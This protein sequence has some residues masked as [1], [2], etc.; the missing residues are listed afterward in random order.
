M[1][2]N[3][4][5][6]LKQDLEAKRDLA[7]RCMTFVM[8]GRPELMKTSELLELFNYALKTATLEIHD[9]S[10]DSGGAE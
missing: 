6:R 8:M 10:L 7:V 2:R 9:L 4:R 1:D 5:E 3:E